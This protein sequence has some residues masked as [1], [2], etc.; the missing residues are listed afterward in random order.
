MTGGRSERAG[1][2]VAA[3][4]ERSPAARVPTLE[5]DVAVLTTDD[6]WLVRETFLGWSSARRA[7]TRRVLCDRRG[8]GDG[9]YCELA[10]CRAGESSGCGGVLSLYH[11]DE[12]PTSRHRFDTAKAARIAQQALAAEGPLSAAGPAPAVRLEL[13]GGAL[14]LVAPGYPARE[15]ARLDPTRERV[16][17]AELTGAATTEDAECVLALGHYRVAAA[18]ATAE[19]GELRR[20]AEL[21]CREEGGAPRHD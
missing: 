21:W 18:R 16:T 1:A 2:E 12:D 7:V 15:L 20:I 17:S 4:T 8:K 3:T 10:I 11:L 6:A 19:E 14:T 5:E 13:A 9:A